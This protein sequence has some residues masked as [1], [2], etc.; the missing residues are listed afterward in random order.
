M[1]LLLTSCGLETDT[2]QQTFANM[3]NKPMDQIH[4]LFIPTAANSPNAIEVLP[5]SL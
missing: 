2:I 1:K 4:A 5:K 3:L